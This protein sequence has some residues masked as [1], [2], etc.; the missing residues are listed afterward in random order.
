MKPQVYRIIA[1]ANVRIG[2]TDR[3]RGGSGEQMIIIVYWYLYSNRYTREC[4][5]TGE[6]ERNVTSLN[7]PRALY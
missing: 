6:R 7:S 4:I 5:H 1:S 2:L 3:N